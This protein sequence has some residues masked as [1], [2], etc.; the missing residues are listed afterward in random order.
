[1]VYEGC[2]NIPSSPLT[3]GKVG[4]TNR[5]ISMALLLCK[6]T[7][8][9]NKMISEIDIQD[10]DQLPVRELYK[11]KPRSYIKLPWMDGTGID[12]VLFFDHIDG[13]YSYCLNM[14][15]EVIHL[16]AWAEVAPLVKKDKPD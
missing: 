1:M 15:N 5:A 10:Y 6:T 3:V 4:N 2:H 8:K 7:L 12:E 16:Q 13:M 11:V 14:Q 9:E